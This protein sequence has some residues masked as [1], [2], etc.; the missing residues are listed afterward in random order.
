MNVYRAI[1]ED[2]SLN[3]LYPSLILREIR[4][5]NFVVS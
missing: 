1:I 4:A 2:T 5:L 3:Y